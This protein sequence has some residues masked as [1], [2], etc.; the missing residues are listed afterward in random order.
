L[1][2][3]TT[4]IELAVE[5]N[6]A[7]ALG[8]FT[9]VVVSVP[10]VAVRN[11]VPSCLIIKVTVPPVGKLDITNAVLVPSVTLCTGANVQ[12]T[13]IVELD[14]NVLISSM[15][16]TLNFTAL[17]MAICPVP[18]GSIVMSALEE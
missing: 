6:V 17:F 3:V 12:S 1:N 11:P 16:P 5:L 13:V 14:V 2:I 10:N 9:A 7:A 8:T 15:Y 4:S 18:C